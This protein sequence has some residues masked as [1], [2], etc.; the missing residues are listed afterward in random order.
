MKF[1]EPKTIEEDLELISMAMEMGIDPFPPKREKKRWGRMAL[2]SFMIVLVI[3]WTS[4]FLM[5][6]LE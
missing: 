2:A 6:F 3:S 5:R 4:E 1:D